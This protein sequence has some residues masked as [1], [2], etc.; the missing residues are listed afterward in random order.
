MS[1]KNKKEMELE[2]GKLGKAG[3]RGREQPQ[4][5]WRLLERGCGALEMRRS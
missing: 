3:Q 4:D 5:A 1:F 2:L